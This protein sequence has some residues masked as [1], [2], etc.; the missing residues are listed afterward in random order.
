M[1]TMV[2]ELPRGEEVVQVGPVTLRTTNTGR[3]LRVGNDITLPNIP[4]NQLFILHGGDQFVFRPPTGTVWFGGLDEAPFMEEFQR[5]AG[6]V[7]EKGGE[8]AFFEAIKPS[9]IRDLEERWGRQGTRRQGDIWMYE[10]PM[11]GW[12]GV[13]QNFRLRGRRDTGKLAVFRTRHRLEGWWA[14]AVLRGKYDVLVGGGKLT[15]PDH[16]PV[17]MHNLTVLAQTA[18]LANPTRAE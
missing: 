3:P 8:L 15:A 2:R 6:D 10:L 18:L 17:V 12:K 16:A 5:E 7:L 13:R 11:F 1:T 4:G 9:I 14:R